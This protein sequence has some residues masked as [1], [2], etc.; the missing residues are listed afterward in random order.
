[1]IQ[2]WTYGLCYRVSHTPFRLYHSYCTALSCFHKIICSLCFPLALAFA[3]SRFV[4]FD[5]AL[6]AY[7]RF[8]CRYIITANFVLH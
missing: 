1:M 4:V 6:K 7:F 2:I 8:K 5:R 3:C